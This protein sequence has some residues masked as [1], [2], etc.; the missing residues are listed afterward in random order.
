MTSS[1]RATVPRLLRERRMSLRA[2]ARAVGVDVAHLS[3]TLRAGA[4][5]PTA[6]LTER[7]AAALDL[8]PHYFPELTDRVFDT[9]IGEGDWVAKRHAA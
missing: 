9:L 3:R 1:F 8:P 6:A 4:R 5:P 2:L 7:V